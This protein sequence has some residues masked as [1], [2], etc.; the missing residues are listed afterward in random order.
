MTSSHHRRHS[1]IKVLS[2]QSHLSSSTHH[3]QPPLH[4]HSHFPLNQ[5]DSQ[6]RKRKGLRS[7]RCCQSFPSPRLFSL[8]PSKVNKK[9][10]KGLASAIETGEKATKGTLGKS[11][12]PV[13]NLPFKPQT[14]CCDR[15]DQRKGNT[16]DRGSSGESK[17]GESA[18]AYLKHH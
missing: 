3:V 1:S 17:Q 5:C 9:V 16:S 12:F 7:R 4:R 13:K 18:V 10:G 11:A 8:T 6:N 2:L 15:I 14:R